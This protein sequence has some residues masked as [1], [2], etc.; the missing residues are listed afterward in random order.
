MNYW[1]SLEDQSFE[2]SF[3]SPKDSIVKSEIGEDK[4]NKLNNITNDES[5]L[6][7]SFINGF[8]SPIIRENSHIDIDGGSVNV[9]STQSK[10]FRLKKIFLKYQNHPKM[11]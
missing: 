8:H 4:F 2:D 11:N 9:E 5:K 1:T 10:S 3:Q 6:I 7:L